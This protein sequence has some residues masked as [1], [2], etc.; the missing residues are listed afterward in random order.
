MKTPRE[1]MLT[2]IGG[3]AIRA[4]IAKHPDRAAF[5]ASP[6]PLPSA[7]SRASDPATS[8]QAEQHL[9]ES[10][11]LAQQQKDVLWYVKQYPGNTA[12]EY[13][14]EN[15]GMRSSPPE[16]VFRRRLVELE[17]AGLVRRGEPRKCR[18]GGRQ[19]ATW[20]PV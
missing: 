11:K 8:H 6:I 15:E 16:G 10:G 20:W 2:T 19:A 9:R 14:A 12:R 13:Q 17:R 18:C 7:L 5:Y 3:E 1:P 4:H